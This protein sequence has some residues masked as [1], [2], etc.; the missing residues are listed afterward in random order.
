MK[1]N[2]SYQLSCIVP[3]YNVERY[4]EDCVVSLLQV[5]GICIQIILVDD[6]STDL[7][8][9]ILDRYAGK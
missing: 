6:G 5:S 2:Y 8:A 3:V 7:S 1:D 4:I 9:E